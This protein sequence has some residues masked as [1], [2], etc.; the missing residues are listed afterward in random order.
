MSLVR[1]LTQTLGHEFADVQLLQVALTHRSAGGEHNERL[2]FLGD[3]ILGFV[4]A[5]QLYRRFPRADEGQLSR[6]RASLVRRE[7]LAEVAK[8]LQLSDVLRMG[9]G[10]LGTGGQHRTST[11]A[12]ALE[13]LLGAVYLDAG[14]QAVAEL[15]QRLFDSRLQQVDVKHV[16]K[17]AKTRLQEW[18]QSRGEELPLYEVVR[19]AGQQHQQKFY[20]SCCLPRSDMCCEGQGSSRRRAEQEA[21]T[22]VLEQLGV[23]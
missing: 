18:L 12:D 13:A 16:V 11:L 15:I 4:I 6:L 3:A 23:S 1:R 22:R 14:M 2:E 21:A 9:A 19:I 17:D 7:T 10:E 20:V 8:E 5:D